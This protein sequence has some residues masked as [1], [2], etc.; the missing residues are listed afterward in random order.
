MLMPHPALS[1]CERHTS[2]HFKSNC[3]RLCWVLSKILILILA[4]WAVSVHVGIGY[5]C[6]CAKLQQSMCRSLIC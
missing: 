6:L 4:Y 2:T 5:L 3:L 1:N